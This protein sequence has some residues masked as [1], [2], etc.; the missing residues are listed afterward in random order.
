MT[1]WLLPS[2]IGLLF[3]SLKQRCEMPSSSCSCDKASPSGARRK[4]VDC[5]P[6]VVFRLSCRVRFLPQACVTHASVVSYDSPRQTKLFCV[7]Y[8][9]NL[10]LQCRL[11]NLPWPRAHQLW[12]CSC[13]QLTVFP[14]EQLSA[15]FV[16]IRVSAPN[17]S[18]PLWSGLDT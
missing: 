12:Q 15:C 17:P 18:S 9:S 6:E 1:P 14:A 5:A 13:L 3:C 8:A 7:T 10:L 11:R 2:L 4:A 16:A